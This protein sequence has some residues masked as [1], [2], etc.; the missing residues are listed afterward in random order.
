MPS[1]EPILPHLVPF[2]LVAFRLGGMF[3]L[4]PMLTSAMIPPRFKV[5][6]VIAMAGSLYPTLPRVAAPDLDLFSLV[7]MVVCELAIG[8]VIG[9]IAAVPLSAMEMAGVVA[10]QQVG[11]GLARVYNPELEA[12]TDILGQL[13][14]YLAIGAFVALNG[15]ETLF[16]S[17]ADT[18]HRVPP[19]GMLAI[20]PPLDLLLGVIMSGFELAMR[21]AAPVT[22]IT[23]LLVVALGVV[24]KTM[25]QLNIMAVGFTLK[26]IGAISI[27]AAATHV[28]SAV[29]GD[30]V[31][32]VLSRITQ[33]AP[34]VAPAI[35]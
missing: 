1:L 33:W 18:F 19:G 20:T 25:P 6:M 31:R 13:L 8:F 15:V 22:G 21:V 26:I 12:D 17:L 32:D 24:G 28:I 16:V 7:P 9:L 34:S 14:F 30:E 23:L 29:A 10:G 5:L 2:V 11:F 27:L 35:R 3:L 4:A